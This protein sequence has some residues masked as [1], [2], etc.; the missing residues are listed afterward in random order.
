MLKK[1][2]ADAATSGRGMHCYANNFVGLWEVLMQRDEAIDCVA[3]RRDKR[4]ESG[5]TADIFEQRVLLPEPPG[6]TAEHQ[7]AFGFNVS[8]S[9][10]D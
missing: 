6:K 3:I 5:R 7:L 1:S 2:C 4:R 10:D 9:P 8:S